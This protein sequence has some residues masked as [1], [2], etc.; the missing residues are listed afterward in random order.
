MEDYPRNP[1]DQNVKNQ[2]FPLGFEP[3]SFINVAV[4]STT[5]LYLLYHNQFQID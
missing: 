4:Y 1:A 2:N 5:V 3:Q